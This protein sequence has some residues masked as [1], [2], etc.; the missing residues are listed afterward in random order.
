MGRNRSTAQWHTHTE[1]R[2]PS[3]SIEG[4][5]TEFMGGMCSSILSGLSSSV[6]RAFAGWKEKMLQQE[7]AE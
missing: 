3:I 6:G 7:A 1:E 5:L 4:T 2:E